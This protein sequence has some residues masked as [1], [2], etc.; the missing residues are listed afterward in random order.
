MTIKEFIQ[1]EKKKGTIIGYYL[2]N[3]I[4]D[5][6]ESISFTSKEKE[7]R[8]TTGYIRALQHTSYISENQANE[9]IEQICYM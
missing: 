1:K 9:F 5:I 3:S 2:E 6:E 4:E 7:K 8:R